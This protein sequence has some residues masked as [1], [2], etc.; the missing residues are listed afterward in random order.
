LIYFREQVIVRYSRDHHQET[1]E[2]QGDTNITLG[3]RFAKIFHLFSYA[4]E[5]TIEANK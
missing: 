1:S 4:Q 3:F 2:S 5:V